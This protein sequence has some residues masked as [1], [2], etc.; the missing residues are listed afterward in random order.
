MITV[1]NA[2]GEK[3]GNLKNVLDAKRSEELNG[4]YTLDL[5]VV[6]NDRVSE[7]ITTESMFE[8]DGNLFD[9]STY[10]S[11]LNEE[12]FTLHLLARNTSHIG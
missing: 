9:V 6:L 7:Q 4:E 10:E 12:G 5:E 2:L 1:L 11:R 3:I 8:D